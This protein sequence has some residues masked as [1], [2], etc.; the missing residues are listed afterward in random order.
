MR[1]SRLLCLLT[2]LVP[3]AFAQNGTIAGAVTF[4]GGEPF[5]GAVVQAKNAAT[6][7]DLKATTAA[8]GKYTIANVPA[9]NYDVTVNMRGVL[10]FTQK[11]IAVAAAKTTDV[12]I[13]LKEGTQLSTLGEDAIGA[14]ADLVKAGHVRH[15][16]LSEASAGTVRRAAAI[17]PVAAL[18]TEYSLIDRGPEVSISS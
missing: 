10:P 6:G 2:L 18:E 3:A 9:G 16:G 8:G 15:V 7:A 13:R 5:V 4:P 14:I 17:H 11:G 1:I 12:N